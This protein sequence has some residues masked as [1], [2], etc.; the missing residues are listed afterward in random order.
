[1]LERLQAGHRYALQSLLALAARRPVE[2]LVTR[3]VLVAQR[4][5][6]RRRRPLAI[7]LFELHQS[8]RACVLRRLRRSGAGDLWSARGWNSAHRPAAP[9]FVCDG[10]LGGLCRWLRAAGYEAV[11]IPGVSAC[12]AAA[13]I[14]RDASWI[15]ITT[16]SHVLDCSDVRSGAINALWVPSNLRRIEQAEWIMRD[17][18]LATRE[19]RCMA[20]GGELS[21]VEKGSVA[22]R[23]P[24]RTA[25]W[26]NEYQI[27][28]GCGRLYWEG[29]HWQKI[30]AHLDRIQGESPVLFDARATKV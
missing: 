28:R 7:V 1:M 10:S 15:L 18:S 20:C 5:S 25:R 9:R 4:F 6:R 16:D 3:L 30:R 12:D 2:A 23:I 14:D 26:K 29:T 17:L 19:P 24:P 11:W 21:D 22:G 13:R 27:C 8:V